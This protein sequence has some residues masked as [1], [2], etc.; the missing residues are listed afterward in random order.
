MRWLFLVMALA[1]TRNTAGATFVLHSPAVVDGGKLPQEYT[2]DGE[3]ATLPLEWSGAPEGATSYTLIMHHIDPEGKTKWYWILYNIPADVT[4]LPKNVK[5]VGTLGNNSINHRAEYAPPHSKAPLPKTYIYT[6]YALSALPKINVPPVEVSRE[7]LLTAMN[8]LILGSA[9]FKV[10]YTS[11]ARSMPAP[12]GGDSGGQRK[13]WLQIHGAELAN[14]E[15]VITL[16]AILDDANRAFA[17]YDRNHDGVI[18]AE[19]LKATGD[20]REGAAFAG[21]IYRHFSDLDTNGDGKVSREELIAAVKYIF[22]TTDL[23][24]AG[25]LTPAEWQNS[26]NAPL[27][28]R[29]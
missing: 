21:L 9:E 4:G 25:K 16:E 2:G 27:P 23:N 14:Q 13:P 19:E 17:I 11:L 12:A 8:G 24:H 3:S 22:N 10:V 20:V 1:V 29:K 7:I 18:T 5:G 28:I 6:V 15:G 26:P